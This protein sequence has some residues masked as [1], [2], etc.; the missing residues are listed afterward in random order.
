MTHRGRMLLFRVEHRLLL[1]FATVCF[2]EH[3]AEEQ[4]LLHADLSDSQDP[5]LDFPRMR[6]EMLSARGWRSGC[7]RAIRTV[8]FLRSEGSVRVNAGE[9]QNKEK[10]SAAR[11]VCL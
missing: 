1:D 9:Q 10:V 8:Y 3:E 7:E 2:E 4:I 6:Q 11:T 5:L